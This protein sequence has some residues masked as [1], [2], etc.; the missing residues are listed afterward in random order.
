MAL[1]VVVRLVLP[2]LNG[3]SRSLQGIRAISLLEVLRNVKYSRQL[4]ANLVAYAANTI[5]LNLSTVQG[6][7]LIDN[8]K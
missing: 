2:L 7:Y 5:S 8:L 1:G 6:I 3:F 4:L